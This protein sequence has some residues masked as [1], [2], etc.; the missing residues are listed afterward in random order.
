MITTETHR[1]RGDGWKLVAVG[2]YEDGYCVMAMYKT[3]DH[4][5]WLVGPDGK[6][7][8]DVS[9][10]DLI[11]IEKVEFEIYIRVDTETET[12]AYY[13]TRGSALMDKHRIGGKLYHFRIV[14]D[15]PEVEE[16]K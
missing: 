12:C 3:G 1:V 2:E 4:D 5:V 6:K 10:Y 9:D 14:D 11:P 8:F 13:R 7:N 15:N 16:V